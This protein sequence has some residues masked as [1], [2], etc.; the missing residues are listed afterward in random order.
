MTAT[1]TQTPTA[2]AKTR[3]ASATA[4]A[5]NVKDCA[6]DK[7]DK[8][9][10]KIVRRQHGAAFPRCAAHVKSIVG[11]NK[12]KA[13]SCKANCKHTEMFVVSPLPKAGN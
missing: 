1:D 13:K 3:A 2:L 8:R 6:T 11:D 9:A 4:R 7:C 5:K 12:V 10:T